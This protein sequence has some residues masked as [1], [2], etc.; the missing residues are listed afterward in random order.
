MRRFVASY[1]IDIVFITVIFIIMSLIKGGEF[2]YLFQQYRDPFIIF[3][4]IWLL[5]SV[6][7]GKHRIKKSL[8]KSLFYITKVNLL[9]LMF[10]TMLVFFLELSYSR[11]LLLSTVFG[12]TILEYIGVYLY[13]IN[14]RFIDDQT[15]KLVESPRLSKKSTKGN[16]IISSSLR[17]LIVNEIGEKPFDFIDSFLNSN[18]SESLFLS[19]S[20]RFNILNQP[21]KTY[22]NIVN[23]KEIN[24]VRRIN[25][26]F[27]AVN[28]K[29]AM[30]G[31]FVCYAETYM[32]RKH[33]ILQKYPSGINWI[34]YFFDHLWKRV[35][36]KVFFIKK[37]YFFIT[38]GYNRVFSKAEILGRLVS[39]GFEIV[40]YKEINNELFIVSKKIKKP[41]YDL[42]PSYGP[43]FKMRR[44][45]QGGK[46]IHVYK[47]RTMHPFS[48]YLQTYLI[49]HNG[50]DN[51]GTGKLKDDF[52]RSSYGKFFR[53][54]WL[55]ELPQLL[56]V[57]KR[58]MNIVGVRP[59][60]QARFD[61]F[62]EDFKKQRNKY[63]PGCLP[64]YV[65]LLMPNEKDNIKAE[66]IYLA[67]KEK[68]PFYTDVKYFFLSIYNILT[69]KIRSA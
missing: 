19:T 63:K 47:L 64:P 36:P 26:F 62:P 68:H 67:E 28:E 35:A 29:I 5:I 66:R 55:D 25:K 18:Y 61:E 15:N 57:L 31:T 4:G 46:I 56:N 38:G 17:A 65:A 58:D 59:L 54:Y 52:R 10:F 49:K 13:L 7:A 30:N 9:I 11:F 41:A 20:V 12:V 48:E 69:N 6:L 14:I 24:Q 45:G 44:V 43:I 21:K 60:S 22:S 50:Y 32:V 42:N 37:I 23:L 2:I 33:N 1:S 27:E 39:C 40:D 34:I 51:N 8:S 16:E 53:K 3:I